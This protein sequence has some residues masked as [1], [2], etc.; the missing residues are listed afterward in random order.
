MGDAYPFGIAKYM[1]GQ[2]NAKKRNRGNAG[3]YVQVERVLHGLRVQ[4]GE[5]FLTM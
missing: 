1:K 3:T 4:V 2:S 5:A